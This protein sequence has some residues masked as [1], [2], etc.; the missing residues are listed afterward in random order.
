MS[1]GLVHS[2]NIKNCR[3]KQFQIFQHERFVFGDS[4]NL[5][6]S[7][8]F[9]T[10]F[11]ESFETSAY[12]SKEETCSET[13]FQATRQPDFPQRPKISRVVS[14]RSSFPRSIKIHTTYPGS[15]FYSWW[16]SGHERVSGTAE[17]VAQIRL[18]LRHLRARWKPTLTDFG[19]SCTSAHDRKS[20]IITGSTAATHLRIPV[21]NNVTSVLSIVLH[22]VPRKTD[23]PRRPRKSWNSSPPLHLHLFYLLPATRYIS[24]SFSSTLSPT[25]SI[26]VSLSEKGWER[27]RERERER[28][29]IR[30]IQ[31]EFNKKCANLKVWTV[32]MEMIEIFC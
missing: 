6:C 23:T 8:K 31:H 17:I 18:L 19:G 20:H 13:T 4:W 10:L 28:K 9:V 2:T 32:M 26:S 22:V 11:E 12:N 30:V 15:S 24:C 3:P 29:S 14:Q 1:K 5:H 7:L 21:G 27:E 16:N 25:L